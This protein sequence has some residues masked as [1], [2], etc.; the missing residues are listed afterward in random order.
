MST[1]SKKLMDN[2]LA[3]SMTADNVAALTDDLGGAP[4]KATGTLT[5]T[6]VWA[7][8]ETVTIGS[9]VITLDTTASSGAN[10]IVSATSLSL[11]D[12]ATSIVEMVNGLEPSV[13]GV[14]FA[15]REVLWTTTA[16]SVAGVVTFTAITPGAAGN[17]IDL[18]EAVTNATI[19]GAKLTGALAP[20]FA[21]DTVLTPAVYADDAA[22]AVAGVP[23]GGIYRK[24][25]GVVSWRQ[26]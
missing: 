18:A 26:A 2:F 1:P 6:G 7:A 12:A 17:A 19:S 13:A 25:T 8:T 15:N 4:T 14:T 23:V 3:R 5:F 16:S 24:A 10:D 21:P 11:A 20:V 9:N 22:A